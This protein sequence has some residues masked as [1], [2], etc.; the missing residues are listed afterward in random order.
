MTAKRLEFTAISHEWF[1]LGTFM[2]SCT[3]LH[4]KEEKGGCFTEA[5]SFLV[6]RKARAGLAAHTTLRPR[7]LSAPAPRV[8]IR[9][10]R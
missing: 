4:E 3:G 8:I 9:A 5:L 10:P 1:S 7:T 2:C 6:Y